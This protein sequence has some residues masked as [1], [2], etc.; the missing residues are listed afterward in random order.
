MKLVTTCEQHFLQL[1]DGSVWTKGTANKDY[2]SQFAGQF[3]AA[4]VVARV[5]QTNKIPRGFSRVDNKKIGFIALPDWLGPWGFVKNYFS[6]IKILKQEL[7]DAAAYFL[8]MPSIISIILYKNFVKQPSG[9]HVVGDPETSFVGRPYLYY[10]FSKRFFTGWQKKICLNSNISIYVADNLRQVYPPAQ[11]KNS[12]V[13]SDIILKQ[14]DIAIRAKKIDNKHKNLIFV[15][16][17]SQLYKGQRELVDAM[18]I[19]K[20]RGLKFKLKIIGG[21]IF[22]PLIKKR[23]LKNKLSREVNFLGSLNGFREI[24]KYLDQSEI[25][26]LPSEQ[27]GM[28]RALI[29]AM[30]RGLVCIASDVGGIPEVL[31]SKFLVQPKDKAVL[32]KKIIEIC[33]LDSEELAKISKSN[34]A[35]ARR[36]IF[37][38]LKN[39]R[40]PFLKRLKKQTEKFYEI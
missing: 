19:C 26:V 23:V 36:F 11:R 8:A 18:R 25:F 29:E 30:A 5:K 35:T 32:A 13:A 34:I 15:G 6:I 4:L 7:P 28:P 16:T 12:V 14:K 17:L 21:G 2:F 38:L 3:S 37:K 22:A 20:D 10:L 39:K 31:G 24:R 40:E 27:E 1:P 9:V 33:D